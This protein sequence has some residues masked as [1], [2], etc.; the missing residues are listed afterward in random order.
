MRQ[1]LYKVISNTNRI[2]LIDSFGAFLTAFFLFAILRTFNE[3]VGMPQVTLTILSV[4]AL[5]FCIYSISCFFYVNKNWKPFL[6]AI[7]VANLM[8]CTL[9]LGLLIHFY[10]QMTFLGITYFVVEIALVCGLVL[11]EIYT[12]RVNNWSHSPNLTR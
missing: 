4:I 9:T 11:F 3:Y 10:P 5:V 6:I 8:Y 2:F 7:I 1:K 12:V